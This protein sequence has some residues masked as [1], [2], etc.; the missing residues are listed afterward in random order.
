[1]YA[2]WRVHTLHSDIALLN[3]LYDLCLYALWWYCCWICSCNQYLLI[4]FCL[5]LF[6]AY[7]CCVYLIPFISAY[8]CYHGHAF[9]V[10]F[11]VV[12]WNV[13]TLFANVQRGRKVVHLYVAGHILAIIKNGEIVERGSLF[14]SNEDGF[15]DVQSYASCASLV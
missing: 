14:N 3:C 8:P 15:D 2:L 6:N 12:I 7:I 11:Y 9:I 5:F 10:I 13:T 1:L 4:I